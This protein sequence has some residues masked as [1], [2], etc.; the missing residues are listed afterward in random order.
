MSALQQRVQ[1]VEEGLTPLVPARTRDR[2]D[3]ICVWKE[4]ESLIKTIR[5]AMQYVDSRIASIEMSIE[6]P[7]RDDYE[8][9][10]LINVLFETRMRINY[11]WYYWQSPVHD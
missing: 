8:K 9:Q 11:L 4:V 2:F 3:R 6:E 5:F 10:N 7:I 1:L